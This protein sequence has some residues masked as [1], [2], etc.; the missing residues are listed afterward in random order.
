MQRAPQV[1]SAGSGSRRQLAL[2]LSLLAAAGLISIPLLT[3]SADAQAAE[4]GAAIETNATAGKSA[5]VDTISVQEAPVRQLSPDG[6]C[7]EWKYPNKPEC[8]ALAGKTECKAEP[9]INTIEKDE[10]K[11]K[12]CAPEE[13]AEC[14]CGDDWDDD[15]DEDE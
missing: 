10:A 7:F 3:A 2:A 14:F 9:S 12:A 13:G 15:E 1:V 5:A 4:S 6:D 8:G 11:R